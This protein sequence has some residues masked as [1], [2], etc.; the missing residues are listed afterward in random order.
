MRKKKYN[1]CYPLTHLEAI[2]CTSALDTINYITFIFKAILSC[3]KKQIQFFIFLEILLFRACEIENGNL[4]LQSLW[5]IFTAANELKAQKPKT[6]ADN[7][8]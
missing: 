7:F 8:Y 6:L 3:L 2:K 4:A 5:L 1:S